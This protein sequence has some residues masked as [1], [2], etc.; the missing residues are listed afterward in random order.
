M[1]FEIGEKVVHPQHGVGE[2][3]KIAN[4]GFGSGVNKEY[5]EI[6]IPGG[7][8]VWV[9]LEPQTFGLRKLASKS[10]I[11]RCRKILSFCNKTAAQFTKGIE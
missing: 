5:Y 8:T 2:V 3:V 9:P 10:E 1:I 11:T 4:R 7:S 6:S